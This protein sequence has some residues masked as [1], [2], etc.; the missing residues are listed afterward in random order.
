MARVEIEIELLS[1]VSLP[2]LGR[3][4]G[5]A[6]SLDFVPGR[7][8][9]AIAIGDADRTGDAADRDALLAGALRFG[10]ALPARG[11]ARAWPV[12]RTWRREKL[13]DGVRNFAMGAPGS[14]V[15]YADVGVDFA[16]P[17]GAEVEVTHRVTLKTAVGPDGRVREGLLFG[18]DALA[19]G[20]VFRAWV[21]GDDPALL[22]RTVRRICGVQRIGRSSRAEFGRV[23]VRRVDAA[24]DVL[25]AANGTASAISFLLVTRAGF[26][27]GTTGMPTLL[28]SAVDLGLP[29]S[30]RLDASRS[31]VR[32][33][34]Y[35]P[36]NAKW[37]RP[38][39][40]RAL[41][42][43]GSVLTF[44]SPDGSEVD[45]AVVH[46]HCAAGVGLWR[47]EGYGE[48]AV[49]PRWLTETTPTLPRPPEARAAVA[50]AAPADELF[51][52]AKARSQ[53]RNAARLSHDGAKRDAE[54]SMAKYPLTSAQWG[55]LHRL[56]REARFRGTD[57]ADFRK[58]VATWTNGNTR[59][60]E[61]A[62]GAKRGG[63]TAA[64]EL[65]R[66][67][68]EQVGHGGGLA[69]YAEHLASAAMREAAKRNLRDE[70]TQ[71]E[72]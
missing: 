26:R 38:E 17:D 40:E 36:F 33:A 69:A 59:K 41:L 10:F 35:S 3:T 32:H 27:D 20:Q 47:H 50:A 9:W 70:R 53:M 31:A 44:V 39:A 51:A 30:W 23:E 2:A 66:L 18:L 8:L 46:A 65:L 55:E 5:V 60:L 45:V 58:Q 52:W 71:E 67:L 63:K 21:A 25:P 22:E 37:Q 24:R 15:Q 64:E 57:G 42:E 11:G 49:Q 62:W 29:A 68:D 19:A 72:E 61:R 34:T 4:L 14:N 12:P 56:A 54:K 13:G 1:D 28:P 7:A 16:T 48:V 43:V 6:P